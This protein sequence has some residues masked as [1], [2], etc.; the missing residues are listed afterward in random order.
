LT[1]HELE[2]M[3]RQLVET[4]K[5]LLA[6]DESLPSIARLFRSLGIPSTEETR[7]AYRDMLLTSPD[8]E[9]Y[10]SGVILFDETIR[11]KTR[12]GTSFVELLERRGIVPG[13]KVDKGVVPLAGSPEEKITDGLDGLRD[14]LRDYHTLGARFTKWRATIRIGE[15]IPTQNCIVTNAHSLARF[16]ALSQES[17]LVPIVEP[18]VLM[19]G[20]HS[21]ARC[22]EVTERTLHAVLEALFQHHV[23]PER[24]LLKPNMVVPGTGHEPQ[25]AIADVASAT[26]SCLRRVVPAAVPGIVFLSGGQSESRATSHLNAMNQI[27]G[28]P[29]V[30]SFSYGRALQSAAMKAWGGRDEN[31][32][33]AQAAFVHRARLNSMA[34]RGRYKPSMEQDPAA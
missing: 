9:E 7:L 25:T 30:L 34:Q 16:A 26:L 6:A 20:H 28:H 32:G 4:G 10:I 31:V 22:F 15:N 1:I 17:D 12:D 23:V 5:G 21:L 18:E 11:Q 27:S 14:R 13:I 29:W 24:M 3:A 2:M 33:A 8:I 19:E